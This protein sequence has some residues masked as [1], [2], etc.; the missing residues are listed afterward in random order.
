MAKDYRTY[1][2]RRVIDGEVY[3]SQGECSDGMEYGW[4]FK[5]EGA[6]AE[7][8]DEICYI[9]EHAFDDVEPLKIDG[10]DFYPADAV[11]GYTRRQLEEL[12]K[13]E[14]DNDGDEIDV[15]YFFQSLFWCFPETRLLEMAA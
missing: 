2:E 5:D 9:P 13:D 8:P 6:F 10:T 12:V 3:Y 14:V 1:G 15:E 7:Q 11:G 4:A